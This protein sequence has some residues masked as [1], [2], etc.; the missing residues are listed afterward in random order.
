MSENQSQLTPAQRVMAIAVITLMFAA[1]F[2]DASADDE[3]RVYLPLVVAGPTL[4]MSSVNSLTPT[5][6]VMP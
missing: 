3:Q 4:V 6:E 5:A 1:A 2:L